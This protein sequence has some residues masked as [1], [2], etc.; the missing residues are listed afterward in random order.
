MQIASITMVG[1]F[2]DGIDLHVR[3]LKWFLS[4][5]SYHIYV[6]TTP[7]MLEQIEIKDEKVTFITKPT[8]K[9]DFPEHP[10]T[11]YVNFW[12]WFPTIIQQNKID[13]EWFMFMEQD[14]WFFEKFDSVP[15]PQTVKTFFPDN[16]PYHNVMLDDK[17]LQRHIWEG[18]H[19]INAAIVN[20]AINF[21]IKF[22]YYADSFLDRNR[23]HYETLFGGK[24]GISMWTRP[25]TMS[26]FS[27]YCALE[28]RVGWKQVEKAV[29]LRGPEI[30]HRKYPQI[31]AGG[32][33]A[34]LDSAQ[35][36]VPDIDVYMAI[37]AYYIAG[38]WKHCDHIEWKNAGEE[39]K[40][41]L[42]KVALTA[43]QWMTG[44]QHAR[45]VEV[46][47]YLD[48]ASQKDVILETDRNKTS[49]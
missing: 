39:V 30:L 20:R 13:P 7:R 33:Q 18:T 38:N 22:A 25:E 3:N 44:E 48:K 2:P 21:K 42:S 28:E 23:E 17:M 8:P 31:Y 10:E 46:L 32:N 36:E 9:D 6:I 24:I 45:L 43:D 26:E 37:A 1:Q 35:S 16:T 47:S 5:I 4:D 40:P 12:R 14:L 11:G 29:H 27:L 41:T 19:L 15:E 49:A 34:L